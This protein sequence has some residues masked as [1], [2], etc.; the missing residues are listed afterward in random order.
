[1]DII[2]ALILGVVQGIT[3]FLPIS[4]TGHLLALH[5]IFKYDLADSLNFD[6]A[7]H[8]GTLLALIFFFWKEVVLIIKHF[9]LSLRNWQVKTDENQKLAWLVIIGAIPAGVA[10]IV[11]DKFIENHTRNLIL[12]AVA[13]IFGSMVIWWAEAWSK[14]QQQTN[15]INFKT[16]WLIGLVQ[17]MALIPGISRSGATIIG[18]L[19]RK[20]DRPTATR[21]AFLVSLPVVAGAGLLKLADLFKSHPGGNELTQV[22]IGIITSAIVGYF[23]IKYFLKFVQNHSLSTFAWYRVVAAILLLIFVWIK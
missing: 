4:S 22:L 8:L 17:I 16:A 2:H 20:L 18:G 14:R 6:A 23:V 3:E 9:F 5:E 11:L 21:Y 12:V 19:F 15:Q 7:L 13:L 1:M 10:G